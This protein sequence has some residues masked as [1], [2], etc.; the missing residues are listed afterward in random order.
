MIRCLPHGR[1]GQLPASRTTR[2]ALS[3][4]SPHA[5]AQ[6]S[7]GHGP[8]V[9]C[10]LYGLSWPLSCPHL[11]QVIC[12]VRSLVITVLSAYGLICE[13]LCLSGSE[14]VAP[15]PVFRSHFSNL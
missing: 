14:A 13:S 4:P 8:F 9:A 11:L 3:L 7:M 12:S 5:A 15:R 1:F 10:S 2:H 6:L